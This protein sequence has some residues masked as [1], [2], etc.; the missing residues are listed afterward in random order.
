MMLICLLFVLDIIMSFKF[1]NFN[2]SYKIQTCFHVSNNKLYHSI[3]I[4]K[5]K[6]FG[7]FEN[8]MIS[9]PL[10]FKDKTILILVS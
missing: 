5:R 3:F 4:D 7:L 6:S 10:K 2:S 9:H 8:K 1:K